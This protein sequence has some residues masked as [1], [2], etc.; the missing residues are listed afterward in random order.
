VQLCG[1]LSIL[2]HCVSL[3]L[4]WKLTSSSPIAS[5]GFSKFAGVL[6]AA[7]S[8]HHLL[9]FEIAQLEFITSTSFVPSDAS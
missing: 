1:S 6:S 4:E 9:G 3:G 8:Q 5:A 7:L 2:W